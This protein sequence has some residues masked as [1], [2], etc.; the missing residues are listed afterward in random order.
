MGTSNSSRSDFIRSGQG[1]VECGAARQSATTEG[2]NLMFL[3]SMCSALSFKFVR[4]YLVVYKVMYLVSFELHS[5]SLIFPVL[6]LHSSWFEVPNLISRFRYQQ[7]SGAVKALELFRK[8]L[9][10]F[11]MKSELLEAVENNQV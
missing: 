7:A 3:A 2:C 6:L 4:Y 5:R 11:Q 9:P 1:E 10:A 8:K